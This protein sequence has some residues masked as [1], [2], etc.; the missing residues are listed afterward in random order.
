MSDH[1]NAM[2]QNIRYM[3]ACTRPIARHSSGDDAAIS[4][5]KQAKQEGGAEERGSTKSGE[6]E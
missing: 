4:K 3:E 2:P 5:R 6:E 1:G